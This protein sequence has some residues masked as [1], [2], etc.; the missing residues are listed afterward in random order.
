MSSMKKKIW[1]GITIVGVM[2]GI[3]GLFIKVNWVPG[4]YAVKESD[5]SQYGPYIL[6][7]EV[8]YTGTGWVQTGSEKG[9]FSTDEYIDINLT[10]GN[11]LPQMKMYDEDY[12]NTFL[13]KIEYEGKTNHVAFEDEI[14]SYYIVEWY[15]VYPVLRDTML[16]GWMYSKGFMTEKEAGTWKRQQ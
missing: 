15:P 6:V 9:I 12:A 5:F 4:K 2:A 13:C 7:Q 8:H 14:D 1:A 16:P 3:I 10:N 11:I